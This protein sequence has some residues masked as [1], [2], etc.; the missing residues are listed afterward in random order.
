MSRLR[1]ILTLALVVAVTVSTALVQGRMRHRWGTTDAVRTT[2]ALMQELPQQFG[3]WR[4][5]DSSRLDEESRN[6]LECLSEMVRTYT[7]AKSGEKVTL[8]FILGPTGPTAAHTPEVCIG[9][10]DFAPLGDRREVAAGQGSDRFWNKRFKSKKL[11]GESLSVYWAWNADGIWKAPK[12]ARY[13]FVG[14]PFLYKAQVTCGFRGPWDGETSV[15]EADAG[16]RF[17]A[18]F[19]TVAAKCVVANIKD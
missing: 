6:Q 12:D 13:A 1:F 7:N 10:R 15:R 11:H 2:A 19:V 4:M 5:T 14:I 3:D 8:L 18:D 17:L 16:Q 9:E